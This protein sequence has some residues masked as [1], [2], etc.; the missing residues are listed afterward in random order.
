M[1]TPKSD[2]ESPGSEPKPAKPEKEATK[3]VEETD[4][5]TKKKEKAE[6]A[7]RAEKHAG[8]QSAPAAKKDADRRKRLRWGVVGLAVLVAL[9]AWLATRGGDEGSSEPAAVSEAAPPRIV[10]EAELKEATLEL[11]QPIYWVGAV[12]GTEL[13]LTELAEGAQVT[14]LPAGAEAGGGSPQALTIGSYRLADPE[15]AVEGYAER[16]GSTVLKGAGGREV[17]TSDESPNSVY[18][19][20]PDNSVQVEVYAGSSKQARGLALSGKVKPIE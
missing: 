20:S 13:Q 14:Y 11:R 18:F 16:A 6:P 12:P 1:A 4:S 5:E 17:V 8:K 7:R 15:A 9:I 10:T 3:P 19:A 2:K